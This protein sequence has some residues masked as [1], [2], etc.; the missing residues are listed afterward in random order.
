MTQPRLLIGDIGGTNA[1]FALADPAGDRFGEV[2]SLAC[3]NYDTAEDAV[4]DYLESKNVAEP[5]VICLAVAGPVI[6][7][8]VRF[9]NNHW[10]VDAAELARRF[11]G[12]RVRL[13]NDFEAIAHSLPR[14]TK[15]DLVPIGLRDQSLKD[16]RDF[17]VGVLGPGTGLGVAGL[18]GRGDHRF[19]VVTEGGHVGFAPE[20]QLQFEVLRH[21]RGRFDR[22]S[23]ERLLCGPG[24]ENIYWAIRKIHGASTVR[25]D[26]AEVFRRALEQS[27]V[28]ATEALN[29][30]FE[31][32][33]QS[34]GNAALS[35]GAYDGIYIGGGIIKRHPDLLKTS[36]FRSGFEN[37][38]RYRSLMERVPT[39]LI[40]H[41]EPGLLGA[42]DIAAG[43]YRDGT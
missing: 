30:F 17:T 29:L 35:L 13:L 33:G 8:S 32:L 23:E 31:A 22:V 25:A 42:A 21:L 19:A 28:H 43:M 20:T 10:R 14:L 6:D 16:K 11:S 38:G 24:L 3:S 34:A 37:K 5:A 18:V 2:R 9:T 40:T 1:R 26:A 39:M 4:I 7:Q 15:D 36:A 27:D 41:P 12:V